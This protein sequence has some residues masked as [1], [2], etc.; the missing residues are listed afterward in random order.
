MK[1]KYEIPPQEGCDLK[2]GHW[3]EIFE[4]Y[5]N[6]EGSEAIQVKSMR[7]AGKTIVFKGDSPATGRSGPLRP[8]EGQVTQIDQGPDRTRFSIRLM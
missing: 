7:V 2:I 1:K 4:A 5:G 8:H 6:A 3:V